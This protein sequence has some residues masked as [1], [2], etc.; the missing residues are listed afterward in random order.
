MVKNKLMT[1]LLAAALVVVPGVV[2]AD[3]NDDYN[4]TTTGNI[5][6]GTAGALVTAAAVVPTAVYGVPA[7]WNATRDY[8]V[9]PAWKA[10]KGYWLASL[11]RNG[12][13]IGKTI[14]FNAWPA[15]TV[16]GSLAVVG[17]LCYSKRTAL[18]NIGKRCVVK[19]NSLGEKLT[20]LWEKFEALFSSSSAAGGK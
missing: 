18:K 6:L 14:F 3:L 16:L 2:R 20:T 7:V 13:S 12:D 1:S 19:L 8:V 11:K 5:A 17:R 15:L 9:N 4:S 10:A